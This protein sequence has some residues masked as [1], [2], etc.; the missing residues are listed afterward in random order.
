MGKIAIDIALLPSIQMTETAILA[1]RHLADTSQELVLSQDDY[2]PHISLA[3]GCI[4]ESSLQP[5][6]NI[7]QDIVN[8]HFPQELKAV[9]VYIGTSYDGQKMSL[10]YIDKTS[11]IQQLH[12]SIM[13]QLTPY[14]SYDVSA[15]MLLSPPAICEQTLLWIQ[16]Y[17]IQ[18]S[19]E[20]F[21]PHITIGFGVAKAIDRPLECA[22]LKLGICHLGNH[23]TC[24]KTLALIEPE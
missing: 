14:F 17:P 1:N 10:Y 23:C 15:D 9:G 19:F 8:A 11:E 6:R 16:N 7:L 22:P 21:I 13:T 18:S 5:L 12:E 4:D 24:R 20:K 2:L 3:M